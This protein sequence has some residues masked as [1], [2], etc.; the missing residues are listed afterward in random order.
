MHLHDLENAPYRGRVSN[1][2][3]MILVVL[4]APTG[5][6]SF[7]RK[8]RKI[9][10]AE[11][12]LTAL[13]RTGLTARTAAYIESETAVPNTLPPFGRI[14]VEDARSAKR[15]TLPGTFA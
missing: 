12:W 10:P 14:V 5:A 6:L 11:R 4:T 8:F 7:S 3:G 13:A 9:C 1:A 2:D 15:M